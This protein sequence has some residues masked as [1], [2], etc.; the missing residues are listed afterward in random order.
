MIEITN[1]NGY[2]IMTV[3]IEELDFIKAPKFS[4]AIRDIFTT[5]GYQPTIMDLEK[6]Y[7]IDSSGL[8]S[9]IHVS[10]RLLDNN[11]E[12]VVVCSSTKI[13]QLFSIAKLETFFKIFDNIEKAEQYLAKGVKNSE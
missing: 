11:K 3:R 6:L 4:E 13:L 8:S 9:L 12:L 7:Y 10:R 1:R 5:H 2:S